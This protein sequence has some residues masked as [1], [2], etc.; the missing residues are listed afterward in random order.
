MKRQSYFSIVCSNGMKFISKIIFSY[1]VHNLSYIPDNKKGC[2]IQNN[3]FPLLKNLVYN[4][5][6]WFVIKVIKA[7][8]SANSCVTLAKSNSFSNNATA[9]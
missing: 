1:E 6:L 3:P 2:S 8:I 7:F 4:V 5:A 9:P